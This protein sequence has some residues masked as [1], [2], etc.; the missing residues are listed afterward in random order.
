M[1]SSSTRNADTIKQQED[2]NAQVDS[3]IASGV[4]SRTKEQIELG[5]KIGPDH[6][7][8]HRRCEGVGCNKLEGRDET[9]MNTCGKC[10]MVGRLQIKTNLL[11][12]SQPFSPFIAA[13]DV[14]PTAGRRTKGFVE[15]PSNAGRRCHL[16]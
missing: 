13:E 7:P 15:N 10:R 16:R 5:A 8:L 2:W 3:Y 4:D 9:K 6:G 14:K 1:G 12:I 11:L